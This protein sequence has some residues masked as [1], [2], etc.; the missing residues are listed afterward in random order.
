[1]VALGAAELGDDLLAEVS[2]RA[3]GRFE[4]WVDR[5]N[6]HSLG[7]RLLD[8]ERRVVARGTRVGEFDGARVASGTPRGFFD[9]CKQLAEFADAAAEWEE[10]VSEFAGATRGRLRMTADVDRDT[11]C[12]TGCGLDLTS[13][14]E[15]CF[16]Q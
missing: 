8:L 1:M 14:K 16:P 12:C 13:E 2:E 11:P 5:G 6:E 9:H 3:L 7:T 4:V 10:P 15:T